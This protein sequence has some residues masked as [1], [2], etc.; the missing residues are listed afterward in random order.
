MSLAGHLEHIQAPYGARVAPLDA[1][2]SPAALAGATPRPGSGS[3]DGARPRILVVEDEPGYVEALT[4]G[5]TVEGFEV[6]GA[7]TLARAR[8]VLR[9]VDCDLVLLDVML[10]DGSGLDL[11]RELHAS[12]RT[13]V[14]VVSARSQEVDV[15]V[16]LELGAADYVTK[17]YRLRELVARIRSVLRRPGATDASRVV[18]G[19][20]DIDLE[21]RT[22]AR[23]GVPVV[24]SRREFDLLA[25]LVER[26][27]QVITRERCLDALWWGVDLADTR[28][29]D[30]HVKR[31]RQKIEAVPATP[32]HLVT[33]R[34][35][36]FR[37]DP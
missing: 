7:G 21:G 20:L 29:L 37:L 2:R 1:D 17:P 28:T 19:D 6:L 13:P 25:L 12:T 11:C 8:E 16:G 3:G 15:V 5:L 30:T 27:G 24:L 10:P 9:E 32:R 18:V 36:G 35:V 14:I 26:R 23:R 31:L 4:L 33:V 34:G 22:V